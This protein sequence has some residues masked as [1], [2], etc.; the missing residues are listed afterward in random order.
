MQNDLM[1]VVVVRPNE[2]PTVERIE[3]SLEAQQQVVGGYIEPCYFDDGT[4]CLV[5]NEEGKLDGLQGN[6]RTEFGVIAGTFFVCGLGEED[7]R[8]LTDD[9]VDKYMEKFS[10]PEN[11]TDEEVQADMDCFFIPTDNVFMKGW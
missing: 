5:C 1:T 8:S 6:R 4:T 2:A 11:I 9:E 3:N 10:E 7:F